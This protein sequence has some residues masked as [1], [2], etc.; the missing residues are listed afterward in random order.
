ML[1]FLGMWPVG[2]NLVPLDQLADDIPLINCALQIEL[3]MPYC[4]GNMLWCCVFLLLLSHGGGRRMCA[5]HPGSV[6]HQ[7]DTSAVSLSKACYTVFVL[8]PVDFM[9]GTLAESAK[10]A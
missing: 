5:K 10:V 9:E 6:C 8:Y 3:T 4:R 2:N 7:R 1:T